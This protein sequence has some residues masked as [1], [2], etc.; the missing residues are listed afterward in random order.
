MRELDG[1]TSAF[2][3]VR[4]RG[5]CTTGGKGEVGGSSRI[6]LEKAE[7]RPTAKGEKEKRVLMAESS[8]T[9]LRII[10]RLN[11]LI[12]QPFL[13]ICVGRY[14]IGMVGITTQEYDY[15]ILYIIMSSSSP[16]H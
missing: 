16:H 7:S 10:K 8:G 4:Q 1:D 5:C 11:L 14:T 13:Y 9:K 6:H 12:S 15:T 3:R 2:S